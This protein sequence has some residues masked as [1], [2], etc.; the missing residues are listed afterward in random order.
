MSTVLSLQSAL[1]AVRF[2]NI[3]P[4]RG[5]RVVAVAGHPRN[6]AVFYFGAVAGGVW[7]TE[8]AG[9]T[10]R[11]VSDDYFKTGSVGAL[12]VSESDPNV[13]YAGMG[14]TTIR[15]DVSYGDGVYKSTDGGRTWHH[16]GLADTRHI[17]K[18]RVHPK[19]PDLVYVAALGHA[20]GTN[21]ERGVF[22]SKDGGATWQNVL[23]KSGKAGAVDISID[24][25]N[26][27][28]LYASIWQTYRNFW[29]LS[30][31]GPDSGLWRS[32]DGGDTWEEISLNKG[33][34]QSLK[35]KI[36]VAASPVK[37]G[38]VWA[39][40][41]AKDAS[42]LYRS[43]D[44]GATWQ[45]LTDNA[46]LLAR[47]W[48]YMHIYA[49]PQDEDTV[50]VLNLAMHKSTDGGRTFI[51][52][53]TP[54]G[55]NH[56][57]WIDPHN[58]RRMIEGNDGGACVS[59]NGGESFSTIY[60]QPTAQFYHMDVDNEFPYRVYGTQQ[61]NS[62]VC[63]PSDTIAGAITWADCEVV[64]T[65]ESG[66]IA[67][68]PDDVNIVYVG[69]VGSAPGGQGALERCDRRTG[70]IQ[71]VNI[72]PEDLHGRGVGEARYRFPWT[73]PILFSPH[74]PNIIY[75][76]GNIAFRSTD[77]GHSW[78][79]ISP[80]LTRA[81]MSKLGPSGGPITLDTSG[82]EHYATIYTFRESPHEAGVFWAG[83][84][85]GLVH[86]SRDG[87]KNWENVTPKD[88]PE[89]SYIRTVEPSPF[90]PGTCYMAATRYKL[91]DPAPYLY[92]TTDYGKSWTKIT[93]GIPESDYTRVI[94]ADT[95]VKG[96]LYAG[97]ETGLYVSL[98]DG[99]QWQRWDSSLPVS[100]VYDLKVKDSDLVVATHGRGFW[101]GD[102]L[103]LLYQAAAL[104]STGSALPATKPILFAPGRV[105]R[106]LP[107]LFAD[108]MPTEG[109]I[110]GIGLGS[111]ATIIGEKEE[112][113]QIKR[114]YLDA[115]EGAPRGAVIDYFLP[116][117]PAEDTKVTL[118][119][120]DADGNVLRTYGTKP[121][122]YDEWDDAK[123]AM[124]PGPWLSLKE[125]MNR[126]IWNL[127]LP[128]AVKVLGNKTAGEANEGPFV[129][130]GR[131]Q[132]RITVGDQV[133]TQEFEVLNDPRV[134]TSR[135]D[136]EE[137]HAL[138]LRIIDKISDAHRG[139]IRLR[140][141]R[142]QIEGWRK[143]AAANEAISNA[144]DA[145]LKTLGEIEDK[146]ILPGD[147]KM[148]YGLIVRS[149]LNV[150]L[151]SVIP[152]VASA[153]ARPTRQARELA[154]LYSAQIDDELVRLASVETSELM[155]LNE[156]IREAE[157][158]AVG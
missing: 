92:K 154:E 133:Q 16:L 45:K 40:V 20:F 84:D 49:D 46:D 156:L 126:F 157:L 73:Y 137:Q 121:A 56:D 24:A 97:T 119:F 102:N 123:K 22:R 57:L 48:Y 17:G 149:R 130:P 41:E 125:G 101:I 100:P 61:D 131:Y 147:Q 110:Y 50:Y 91:D 86:L 95:N 128:G 90:E 11:C 107:D 31:G 115:G 69:A 65:G 72:W 53:P 146:L 15:T 114:T 42:G 27:D 136:L 79:P 81:D 35:G 29:E 59:F 76:C 7:K 38:R 13:I 12:C 55:D 19:N 14:E 140:E 127:R 139:V 134:T 132:V 1:D 120:L 4:T 155:Q 63:V 39:M 70:Q 88:L 87:G 82:A 99:A 2:R 43:E 142:T 98:D 141:L 158:P 34:P 28:I 113:G 37:A 75:A 64:G 144:A 3:G 108:W 145:V 74:D 148:T 106:I 85:D 25:Q 52:I 117:Q 83:S 8:D 138:H 54:H 6:P 111:G 78:E 151:A 23:Y 32:K 143:R 152:I 122:G 9:T 135:Q 5:G 71:M 18:V 153:D 10:W 105:Y 36:G 21:E 33:F 51:E 47:P 116:E 62:S 94:R 77:G 30:S 96:I 60:N 109:K 93:N 129:L 112:T 58:N 89:W 124:D 66:Y 118:E 80:D 44:F 26:P 67:V 103:T 150:S 68:K 104:R